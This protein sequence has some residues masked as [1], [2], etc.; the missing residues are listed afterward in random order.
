MPSRV[1]RIVST[2]A[3]LIQHLILRLALG[4]RS[5][6]GDLGL[7]PSRPFEGALSLI[8]SVKTHVWGYKWVPMRT[9]GAGEE[10][11]KLRQKQIGVWRTGMAHGY[12]GQPSKVGS[13]PSAKKPTGSLQ[14]EIQRPCSHSV[15]EAPRSR[16]IGC[17]FC[18]SLN[19][20]NTGLDRNARKYGL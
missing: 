20:P 12:G 2:Q 18:R 3:T 17:E 14:S 10:R 13:E 1:N 19:D 7:P 5:R 16:Q 15:L 9:E 4:L 8:R 6:V 11:S